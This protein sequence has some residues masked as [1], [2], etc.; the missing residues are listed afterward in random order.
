MSGREKEGLKGPVQTCESKLTYSLHNNPA[1]EQ[2][3]HTVLT[4]DDRG[5]LLQQTQSNAPDWEC[6]WT[7]EYSDGRLQSIHARIGTEP[8]VSAHYEYDEQGRVIREFAIQSD[9][10]EI[11]KTVYTYTADGSKTARRPIPAELSNV[12]NAIIHIEELAA[13]P[14]TPPGATAIVMSYHPP[15][16]LNSLAFHDVN[17][18]VLTQVDLS[19]DEAGRLIE[20]AHSHKQLLPPAAFAELPPERAQILALAMAQTF[21][22]LRITHRYDEHGN[23]IELCTQIGPMGNDLET[24]SYNQQGD[25]IHKISLHHSEEHSIDE[26]GRLTPVAEK[27]SDHTSETR[28]TYEYDEHGNWLHKTIESSTNGQDWTEASR[29]HRTITY[30]AS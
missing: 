20:E 4:F 26:S 22:A 14:S 19:Y 25:P 8:L 2:Y 18:N 7:Y 21:G 30:F 3:R 17:D 16:R 11:A 10:A 5:L 24:T 23:E 28:F 15:D 6:T 27:A 9:G 29:E 12:R 1:E 13:S